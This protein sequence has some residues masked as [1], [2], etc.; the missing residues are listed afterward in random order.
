S[1]AGYALLSKDLSSQLSER[2]RA[3]EETDKLAAAS[4]L[5]ASIEHFGKAAFSGLEIETGSGE[6]R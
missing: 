3:L 2:I 4:L 6:I 5:Q 1:P